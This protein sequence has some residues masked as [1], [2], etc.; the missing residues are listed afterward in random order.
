MVR[1]SPLPLRAPSDTSQ[2]GAW[3]PLGL[4]ALLC[5][6]FQFWSWARGLEDAFDASNRHRLN[7]VMSKPTEVFEEKGEEEQEIEEEVP[8]LRKRQGAQLPS[9]SKAL[10]SVDGQ[11]SLARIPIFALYVPHLLPKIGRAHV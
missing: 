9:Y 10:Q 7:E 11:T 8:T 5:V 2:T 1:P 4:A 6:F 3:F